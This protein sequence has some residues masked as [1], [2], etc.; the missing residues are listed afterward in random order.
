[1]NLETKNSL[2]LGRQL[3]RRLG[4]RL[5]RYLTRRLDTRRYR[6]PNHFAQACRLLASFVRLWEKAART[7][8]HVFGPQAGRY[9]RD[10]LQME[11]E[12]REIDAA[13]TRVYGPEP[14]GTPSRPTVWMD[15]YYIPTAKMPLFRKWFRENYG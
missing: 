14:P 1:M 7:E 3:N 11:R 8:P 15:R 2:R 9:Y 5:S 12:Q 6:P 13:L 4:H 10:T